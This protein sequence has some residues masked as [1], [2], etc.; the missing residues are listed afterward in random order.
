MEIGQVG[1]SEA[2]GFDLSFQEYT[3]DADGKEVETDECGGGGGRL[4]FSSISKDIGF[5]DK[6]LAASGFSREDQEYI[7]KVW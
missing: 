4:C 7:E 2:K 5:L 3:V 6:E 1:D